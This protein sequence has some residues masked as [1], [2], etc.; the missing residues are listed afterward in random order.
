LVCHK[1][2]SK[3]KQKQPPPPQQHQETSADRSINWSTD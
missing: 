2:Q 3:Q 1:F